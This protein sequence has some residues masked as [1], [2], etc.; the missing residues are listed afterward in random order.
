[1]SFL[2]RSGKEDHVTSTSDDLT[3]SPFQSDM[4][5]AFDPVAVPNDQ[6]VHQSVNDTVVGSDYI[7][8]THISRQRIGHPTFQ[9]FPLFRRRR[10]AFF[11]FGHTT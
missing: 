6:N 3:L 11:T 10:F 4:L 7:P 1:M 8:L 5:T 2:F 9:I